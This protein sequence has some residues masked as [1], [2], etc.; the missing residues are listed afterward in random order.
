R[1][2]AARNGAT[3]GW[4]RVSFGRLA[5]QLAAPALVDAGLVAAGA[6]ALEALCARVVHRLADK[7]ALGRF[8]VVGDKPGLPRALARPIHELRLTGIA[9]SRLSDPDLARAYA[10]YEVELREAKLADRAD[11]FRLATA[12]VN[13][14]VKDALLDVPTL[15][16]DVAVTMPLEEALVTAVAAR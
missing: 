7:G 14:G 11:V 13:S 15:L 2:V 9:P 8:A 12:R 16:L 1:P 6:V 10:A 4:T 3:F 5:A